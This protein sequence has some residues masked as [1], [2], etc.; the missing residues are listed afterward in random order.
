MNSPTEESLQRTALHAWHASYGARLV[1]FA[2]W[3]MPVQYQGIIQEHEACRQAAALF[4]VSHMGRIDFVGQSVD[5]WL[6]ALVTRRVVG[7]PDG[8]VR[9]S[10]VCNDQ[11]G[12]L[13]DV[14][15]YR[16]PTEDSVGRYSLVV[17]ASNRDKLV[18]WFKAHG[19]DGSKVALLD[20]TWET[21]MIAV[22]GPLAIELVAQW[23]GWD[24]GSLK[25]YTACVGRSPVGDILVGRTGYTGEDGVELVV[26]R[27]DAERVWSEL[28]ELG[29]DRGVRAAGLGARDTLRLEA[30]MPLYGHELTED[31]NAAGAGLDFAIQAKDRDFVGLAA[32]LAARAAGLGEQRVGL[33]LLGKRPAREGCGIVV[34]ERTVGVVT[35]GT[36]SPTLGRPIA[37]GY[38]EASLSKEGTEVEIDIR[39]TRHAA[40][41]VSLPFYRRPA[42]G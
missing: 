13:D 15:I 38:L 26:G 27:A 41:V 24:P 37:M 11:G 32:I 12:V 31:R 19:A 42:K 1:P 8:A 23:L 21:A 3:E 9:Y 22:Q 4:D 33:E 28:L 6:D 25:Y 40:R 29:A 36:F 34:E 35:S 2:G 5:L 17:N 39:G 10:L 16:L 14:L 20:R 30:G 7:M 18:A